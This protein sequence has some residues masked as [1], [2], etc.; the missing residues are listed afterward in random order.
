MMR[1]TCLICGKSGY[2]ALPYI[3]MLPYQWTCPVGSLHGG[4]TAD[5]YTVEE[6]EQ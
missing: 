6:S 3:D 1:V 4:T 2:L 5:T